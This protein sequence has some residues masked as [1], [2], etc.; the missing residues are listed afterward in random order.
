MWVAEKG[1]E[2]E[3]GKTG[4]RRVGTNVLREQVRCREQ[5]RC[6]EEGKGEEKRKKESKL[7]M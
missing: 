7:F 1:R 3:T 5:T 6:C 4:S 2:Y